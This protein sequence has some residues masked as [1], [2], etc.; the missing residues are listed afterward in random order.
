MVTS[1]FRLVEVGRSKG[2]GIGQCCDRFL[3][4]HAVLSQIGDSLSI[5]PLEIPE[6]DRCHPPTMK[7][8]A[9]AVKWNG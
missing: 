4:R 8:V 2:A 1:W 5:I 7:G 6:D 3:E 9:D